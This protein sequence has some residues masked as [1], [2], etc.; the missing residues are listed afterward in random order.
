MNNYEGLFIVKPDLKEEDIKKVFKM[1]TDN[2]AKN[3]G[4]VEKEDIWGKK[5]LAYPVKKF[6]EGYYYKLEFAVS[7][8]SISKLETACKLNGD[9]LRTLISKK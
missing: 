4:T 9:I 1:I 2:I 3:N 5:Q 8:D 7:P 6:K